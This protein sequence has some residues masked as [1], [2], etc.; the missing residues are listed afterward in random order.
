MFQFQNPAFFQSQIA[1]EYFVSVELTGSVISKKSKMHIEG[2]CIYMLVLQL[3]LA[4]TLTQ[5]NSQFKAMLNPIGGNN[6]FVLS[7]IS[8]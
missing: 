1:L 7:D 8:C 3:K 6:N 2:N 5:C 4:G